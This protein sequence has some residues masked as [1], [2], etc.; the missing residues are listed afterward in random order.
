MLLLLKQ[1]PMAIFHLLKKLLQTPDFL[2][3]HSMLFRRLSEPLL[4]LLMLSRQM[5]QELKFIAVK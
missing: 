3:M 2:R 5:M 1:A 4:S